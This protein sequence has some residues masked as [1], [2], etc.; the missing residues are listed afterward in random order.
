MQNYFIAI[1]I[2][3]FSGFFSLLIKN[4]SYKLKLIT[5]GAVVAS[6]FSIQGA[7]SVG[8][9]HPNTL[10]I[11]LGG[12]FEN[13]RFQLDYLSAFFVIFISLMSALSIIYA[14]GYLKPYINKGKDL[15]AHCVFLPLLTASML[16]VVGVSNA[17]FFLV[18]WELMSLSSFFL[19][20]FEHEKKETIKAGIKY[21]VY[22]HISV[23]FIILLFVVLSINAQSLD[24]IHYKQIFVDN[25]NLSNIV[26]LLGFIGFGIKAGFVPFHNWL[27]DAHPAA[28]SHVSSMMS[29]VMIKTGIYGILRVL[30]FIG[31]P[32]VEIGYFVLIISIIS[33]LWGVLYAICQH[34]LKKLLA[35]HSIENIGIIGIGIAL[36]MLGLAYNNQTV[37]VLGFAGGLLHIL[38]HSIFKE[39][40]FLAA[41]AVY[42]KTHTRNIELLGGLIKKMPYTS[43][44]FL[45]GAVA[46]CGLPPFN[47]FISEFLIYFSMLKGLMIENLSMFLAMLLAICALG[48]IGTMAILCF[49]KAFGIAFLGERRCSSELALSKRA[50][51]DNEIEEVSPWFIFPMVILAFLILIIGLFPTQSFIGVLIPIN[52]LV[53]DFE[54]DNIFSILQTIATIGAILI[55]A[56]VVLYMLK[57]SLYKKVDKAPTWGCGY[58]K[59]TPRMQYSATSYASVFIKTLMPLFKRVVDVKKPKVIFQKDAHFHMHLEDVE[60]AYFIHPM[61]KS[62]EK[63]FAKFERIQN[64]NIQ[65]YILYGLIF[66]LLSIIAVVIL[67]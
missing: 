38:N 52:T 50:E 39:L 53:A 54:I 19:V 62:I 16:L 55:L 46:I 8:F 34:D 26:F 35:Y 1:L 36:G 25:G 21:L 14:N 17:L 57:K 3:L 31:V 63:F 6:C 30:S 5:L 10:I 58:N 37:A 48:L 22:M 47:G 41:G 61:I 11:N 13:V 59:A 2:L 24:F 20:I 7:L 49:T 67:G 43:I 44:L 42:S 29:G 12:I 15:S 23:V 32:G 56:I 27:P 40:L 9:G 65:S 45:I 18:V 33:G 64:G 66:L 51:L 28:P 4:Q 60:E